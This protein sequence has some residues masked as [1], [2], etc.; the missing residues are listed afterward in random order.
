M[1]SRFPTAQEFASFPKP[2]YVDP[3]TRLPLAMAV[4]IPMTVLVVVSISCRFYSRTRIVRT[5]GWD[6]WIMLA[7][8]VLCVG[9]NIMV[10]VSMLPQYQMGYHLWDIRPEIL[11][12][13]MKA[14]QMGMAAQLL[15]TTI[16]GLMKIAIL[17][18]YLRIF[19]SRLNKWF[20][21]I[22][23]VY[24]LCMNTSAFFITL[25]QCRP[26]ATYWE[27]FK[28]I[29]TAKC[30][31]IRAIYY[32]HS[33]QNTLSD[34][35]IFLWPARDLLNVKIS[36]RQ[37][38]TLTCMFSLG[39]IVCIAGSLRIYYTSLYLESFDVF[40]HGG[41]TFIVMSVESGI[42]VACGCLPGCKP[43]L[44]KLFPRVFASSTQNSYGRPSAKDRVKQLRSD[45]SS[46]PSKL[47]DFEGSYQLR[48]LDQDE[49]V[50]EFKH[51]RNL[52]VPVPP[53][54]NMSQPVRTHRKSVPS[55]SRKEIWEQDDI[56]DSSTEFIILQRGSRQW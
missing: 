12:N 38:V 35:V 53:P 47:K 43:L 20:C 9:D 54:G 7:A 37:R 22:M 50:Q 18:T 28:H 24:T 45:E 29:N 1:T 48:A 2:N 19:P 21:Y 15:F 51:D 5:L 4:I 36:L 44:N 41:G 16:V 52:S 31:N 3:S 11:Y 49:I 42:G 40:W 8:A 32:F 34:F 55:T 13:T 10:I 56:S 39:V 26:V 33:A 30:L 14:A 23:I 25:F 27:I 17:L 46:Q 6:D